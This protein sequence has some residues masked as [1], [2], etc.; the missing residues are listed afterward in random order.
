MEASNSKDA[1]NSRN[2]KQQQ[3]RQQQ[4]G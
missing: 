2:D 4:Q 3:K 1:I